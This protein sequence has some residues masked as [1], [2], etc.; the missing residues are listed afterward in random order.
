ME[1]R[2]HGAAVGLVPHCSV[3]LCSLQRGAEDEERQRKYEE[4]LGIRII[5]SCGRFVW[6]S[7]V[8]ASSL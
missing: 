5:G 7:S 8:Y 1:G 6:T 2:Q 3:H 4:L